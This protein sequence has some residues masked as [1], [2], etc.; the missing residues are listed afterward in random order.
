MA[1]M[2]E[3]HAARGDSALGGYVPTLVARWR[4]WRSYRATVAALSALT[5]A[6]LDDIGVTRGD[7]RAVAR[8][9]R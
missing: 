3:T 1:Y 7:I 4:A 5:D 6:E 2:S 9:A 8:R